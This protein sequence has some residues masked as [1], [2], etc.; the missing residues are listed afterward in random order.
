M[1]VRLRAAVADGVVGYAHV[2]AFGF[3]CILYVLDLCAVISVWVH[4]W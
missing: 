3:V 1:F 2:F 4:V